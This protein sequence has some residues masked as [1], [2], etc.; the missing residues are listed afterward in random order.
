MDFLVSIRKAFSCESRMRFYTYAEEE[1][2]D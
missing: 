1:H 2:W